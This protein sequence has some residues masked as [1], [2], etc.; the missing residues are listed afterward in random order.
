MSTTNLQVQNLLNLLSEFITDVF[1]DQ[2]SKTYVVIA[3]DGYFK[4]VALD[5]SDFEDL[6][7]NIAVGSS[8]VAPKP[9]VIK[10]LKRTLRGTSSEVRTLYQRVARTS[11]EVIL[12]NLGGADWTAAEVSSSGVNL[13]KS[14]TPLFVQ[15]PTAGELP[16]PE[17]GGSLHELDEFI[18][19]DDPMDLLLIKLWLVTSLIADI[20]RP[21]AVITGIRGSGKT[22]TSRLLQSLVDPQVIPGRHMPRTER[23]LVIA[24]QSSYVP[25]LENVRS[26]SPAQG[27]IMAQAV[28]DFGFVVRRLFTDATCQVHAFRRTALVTGLEVPT[29]AADLL[30]RCL[31]IEFTGSRKLGVMEQWKPRFQAVRPRLFGAVLATLSEAMRLRPALDPVTEVNHRLADWLQWAVAVGLALGA[32]RDQCVAA[33][34][35]MKYRQHLQSVAAQ[36][37]A[38]G[39]M[40]LMQLSSEWRGTPTRLYGTLEPI[41][42]K[43][44]LNRAPNWPRSVEAMSK[45]VRSVAPELDSVGIEVTWGQFGKHRERFIEIRRPDGASQK[46]SLTLLSK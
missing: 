27:D 28:T 10:L 21:L 36:P 38:R 34:A 32:S 42:K 43:F 17:T 5:S 12:I 3:S 41:S 40:E 45:A 44:A 29:C 37:I 4:N 23:D 8:G 31:L 11:S 24:L 19:T 39:V 7:L 20:A 6:I 33:L 35:E 30:S 9:G 25:L 13:V 22:E 1:V 18:P 2:N 26:I 16:L 46:P 14:P 15:G